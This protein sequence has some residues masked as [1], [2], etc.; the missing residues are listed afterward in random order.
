MSATIDVWI[1]ALE[2]LSVKKKILQE[3][4]VL[5]QLKVDLSML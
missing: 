3:Y 2:V 1:N 5:V 4:I